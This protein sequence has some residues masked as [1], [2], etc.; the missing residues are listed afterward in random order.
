M[1]QPYYFFSY[2][3]KD[4]VFVKRLAMDLKNSNANVWLDQLDISPGSTWDDS[5][6]NALNEAQGL[7]VILSNISV[8]SPNVM[9]EVSYALSRG[10]KVVPLMIEECQI[11]FRLARLQYVDFTKDY[12]SSFKQLI[13]T[14]QASEQLGAQSFST[15]PRSQTINSKKPLIN[16][17]YIYIT[18][19]LIVVFFIFFLNN[20]KSAA[21]DTN[22]VKQQNNQQKETALNSQEKNK[23]E[24]VENTKGNN[25]ASEPKTGDINLFDKS[26]ESKILVA[27][28]N[29]W[30]ITIDGKEDLEYVDIGEDKDVV[31]GFKDGRSA[32]F[33][34]FKMLIDKTDDY[35]AKEF[36]LFYGN[37]SPTGTFESIGKFTA[38]NL[39][40]F[41][42]PY[43]PFTFP[44][45]TAKYFKVKIL[46]TFNSQRSSAIVW[47]FQLWGR[48][49]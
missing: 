44:S 45:V 14:L 21:D 8:K 30:E 12:D 24:V 6:Q 46:S 5:V 39:K 19:A 13:A 28:S 15:Q 23:Q 3:R 11:P 27:S 47:E 40:F 4:S 9:D 33:N 2:S 7:I 36:Q 34:T 10:K 43:Q 1:Q 20:N 37:D 16:P 48:L 17:K 26:N 49:N 22:A 32:T 35:N 18:I 25:P 42:A 41:D 31:Y 29:A 38:Q